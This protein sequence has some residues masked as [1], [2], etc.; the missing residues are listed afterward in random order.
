MQFL[1]GGSKARMLGFVN[2]HALNSSADSEAFYRAIAD[3]D[4]LLRDGSGMAMLYRM[5]RRDPGLNMNGTDFIPKVLAAFRGRKVALWGT[6]EP[7]VSRASL[8]CERE[9]GVQVVSTL[10]G[11]E[12]PR[13]YLEL[14]RAAT[15]DLILL[16]MGMPKQEHLARELMDQSG[17]APLIV[18]GGAILDFL[19]G[20]A[21]RAPPWMRRLGVEW[22]YRL[23]SEPMRLFR[24]YV[25]G[26]PAFM[27]RL[28]RWRGMFRLRKQ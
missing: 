4:V 8:R 10:H 27:L 19:G 3:A 6:T 16:G 25:I 24:R 22:L 18:C 17:Q 1:V 28:L 2:A 13:F 14:A 15:P 7:Y 11:F 9:F 21:R 23:A 5:I 12:E 26:N 20:K